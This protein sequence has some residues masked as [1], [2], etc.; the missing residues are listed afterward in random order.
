MCLKILISCCIVGGSCAAS[1]DALG[2]EGLNV[3]PSLLRVIGRPLSKRNISSSALRGIIV[4]LRV[5]DSP[6]LKM[7]RALLIDKEVNQHLEAI[8]FRRTDHDTPL[9]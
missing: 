9:Q 4:Q 6:I 5:Q 7:L 2:T 3:N 8:L 1:N